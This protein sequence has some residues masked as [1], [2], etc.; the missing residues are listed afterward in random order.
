MR[1]T[2]CRRKSVDR[3]LKTQDPRSEGGA[4]RP[5][6]G[7]MRAEAQASTAAEPGLIEISAHVVLTASMQ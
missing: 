4:P 7:V 6:L 5:M 2:K 1:V 3:I